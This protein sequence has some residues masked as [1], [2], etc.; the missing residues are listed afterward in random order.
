MKKKQ[1]GG[2]IIGKKKIWTVTY[3]DDTALVENNEENLQKMM[4]TYKRFLRRKGLDL[5]TEKSKIMEFRKAGGRR[6]NPKFQWEPG[7]EIEKVKEFN[8]LGYVLK[9]DNS[10]EE[11]IRYLE[12]KGRAKTE[13]V[14]SFGERK[15]EKSW[16]RRMRLFDALVQSA[17]MYEAEIWALE[18]R[19]RLERLE[20]YIRWCLEV[21]YNTPGY[22][23]IEET[24][25]RSLCIKMQNRVMKFEVKMA[26]CKEET[27]R[28]ECW[29][30]RAE[31][32]GLESAM[33]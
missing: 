2:W 10:D 24:G 21:D 14:W 22:A 19:E 18:K 12:E 26:S 15:F 27:I 29:K 33:G 28:K 30:N 8:Y 13:V 6:K 9:S 31:Q 17:M 1:E 11:Q 16:K 32:R 25:R 3:A 20:R 5:N 4:Q 23:V 7:K